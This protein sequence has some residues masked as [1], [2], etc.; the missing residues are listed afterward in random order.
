MRIR[1]FATLIIGF[2][3]LIH[4]S[5]T[6]EKNQ[7]ENLIIGRWYHVSEEEKT[8][9]SDTL[10]RSSQ[11]TYVPPYDFYE[12]KSD[13]TVTLNISG[14]TYNNPYRIIGDTIVINNG[15]RNVKID[16]LTS[17]ELAFTF[18]WVFDSSQYSIFTFHFKK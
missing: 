11:A 18:K 4:H 10:Y 9:R 5:C 13:E 3:C 17:T 1:I 14:V 8:F 6:K 2:V 15:T 12:F 7:Y 16:T